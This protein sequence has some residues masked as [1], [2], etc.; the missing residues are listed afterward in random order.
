MRKHFLLVVALA[1]ALM[2]VS[3]AKRNTAYQ[4]DDVLS[5]VRQVPLVGNPLDLSFGHDNLYVAQD[6]GGISII[7]LNTYAHTWLTALSDAGGAAVA[8]YKIRKVGVVGEHDRMFLNETD[9]TD[10]IRIVDLEEPDTLKVIDAI[11]GA[12][13][14]IQDL[15]VRPIPNPTD[16]NIIE[17]IYC[18][19]RNVH[20]GRYNGDLWLGSSFSIYPPASA[21]GIDLGADY[22][23]VAA[24][25]R[26]LMIYARGDQHLVGELGLPG[27][28]QKVKVSGN[29]AYVACRQGGFSVVDVSDPAHPVL[30]D[31]FDTVGYATTVDLKDN[32]AA[33]SSGS[34]GIY[35]FDVSDPARIDLKQ[36]L[37]E[38]GYTNLARFNGDNLI[39]AARDQGIMIYKID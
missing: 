30:M 39:V 29:Y 20:Y 17:L 32:L 31:S 11:T 23:Y 15:L 28:A 18:A 7:D 33:V 8:L 1:A 6:Q 36:R 5:F 38:A 22:V 12:T 2:L 10:L 14:D 26:G 35:L 19:G 25:Q 37:S 27:E 16:E 34:G 3:C 4:D 9:G 21:S 13:Q 24:E